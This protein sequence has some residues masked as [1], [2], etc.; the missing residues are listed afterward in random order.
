MSPFKKP[1]SVRKATNYAIVINGLQILLILVMLFAVVIVPEIETSYHLL[2]TLTIVASLVIIW[3]AVVD[4]RE[5]LST[6]KLLNQL[7]DMDNTIDAMSQFNNTLRAQ[8]HDFL[9]HLQVVYSLIEMEEYGEA[10]DY[11]EQVYGRITAVSRVMKTAIPAVNA[12][13]QVKVAGCERD[14][15]HVDVA[16]TSKWEALEA[17]MPDWEMCKVLS[18]LIDNAADAMADMPAAGQKLRIELA[19]NVKQYTFLVENNGPAIPENIREHIFTP[20]FTTKGDGH[21]M[22]LHIVGETLRSRGGG[23][24]VESDDKRTAFSGFVPKQSVQSK[25]TKA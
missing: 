16:I 19:E 5:A 23:I 10:N 2:L 14:G 18:N 13:L 8:R 25:T 17:V 11:I 21:G 9:N 4:I 15:I 24:A 6:R 3:G 7:D 22:G 12:L 20:G 1:V